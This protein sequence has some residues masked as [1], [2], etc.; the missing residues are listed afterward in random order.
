[1]LRPSGGALYHLRAL[2]RQALWRDFSRQIA[3]WLD[4]WQ[5]PTE[6]LILIGPSGGYTLPTPWLRSFKKITAYDI[7]PLAPWFFHRQHRLPN[8]KF[9]KQ[10]LFWQKNKLSLA[11]LSEIRSRNPHA[12]VLF[13]N[14]LGQ[15][16][17]EGEVNE[18]GWQSYLN[19]LRGLLEGWRWASYHDLF[20][21]DHLPHREHGS[22]AA[23]YKTKP[24]I[25]EAVEP[26]HGS[27]TEVTDHLMLGP[28]TA[29]LTKTV[30]PWSLSNTSLHL[31]E[32]VQN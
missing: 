16:P 1:M 19:H 28:W 29:G 24:D 20:T 9:I 18:A 11:H 27:T 23:L 4:Q 26:S 7:D 13:C 3:E 21:V 5:T 31:I 32:G 14:V 22:V 15:I 6:E 25:S 12:S 8:V 2:T 10:D 17:L 30:F